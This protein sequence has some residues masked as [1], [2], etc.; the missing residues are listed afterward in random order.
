MENLAIFRLFL[1]FPLFGFLLPD[2][3]FLLSNK[4]FRVP[5]AHIIVEVTLIAMVAIC[6]IMISIMK[7]RENNSLDNDKSTPAFKL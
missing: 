1:C 5:T 3:G 6:S 2:A 4:P 7:K